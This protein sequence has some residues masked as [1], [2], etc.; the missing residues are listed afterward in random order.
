MNMLQYER[1]VNTGHFSH[2]KASAKI[3]MD[4]CD[5]VDDGIK[6][7]KETVGKMLGYPEQADMFCGEDIEGDENDDWADPNIDR[8]VIRAEEYDVNY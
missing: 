4:E 8:P 2:L 6:K 5:N 3:E 1:L 7:A